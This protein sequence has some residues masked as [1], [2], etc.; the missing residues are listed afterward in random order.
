LLYLREKIYWKLRFEKGMGLDPIVVT[1]DTLEIV[2][3]SDA[4]WAG[5][6]VTRSLGGGQHWVQ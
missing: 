1:N 6:K 5:D 4:D 3:Y 2:G